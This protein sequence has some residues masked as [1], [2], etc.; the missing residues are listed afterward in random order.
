MSHPTSAI[1]HPTHRHAAG[2]G[3]L[4]EQSAKLLDL[5]GNGLE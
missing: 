5:V 1:V 4:D 3:L 2:V